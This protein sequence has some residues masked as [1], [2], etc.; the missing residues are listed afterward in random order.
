MVFCWSALSKT[1]VMVV[2]STTSVAPSA[3]V[4]LT[5]VGGVVSGTVVNVQVAVVIA[6]PARSCAPLR[7]A[8]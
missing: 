8:V 4:V 5:S 3:G 1:A 2:P 6:L 7:V